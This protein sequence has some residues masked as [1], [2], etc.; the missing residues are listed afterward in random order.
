MVTFIIT[1]LA[2]S[3]THRVFFAGQDRVVVVS[4]KA[5]VVVG[6]TKMY[7]IRLRILH[8]YDFDKKQKHESSVKCGKVWSNGNGCSF[9]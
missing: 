2:S 1:L 7:P 3:A 6:E 8:G 4:N 5:V 9:K